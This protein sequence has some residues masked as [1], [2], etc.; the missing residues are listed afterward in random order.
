MARSLGKLI[1][2]ELGGDFVQPSA[3]RDVLLKGFQPP[4]RAE[5]GLLQQVFGVLQR[6]K[7][8]IAMERQFAAVGFGELKKGLYAGPRFSD[9]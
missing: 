1:E 8:A 7:H 6:A 2:R 9:H 5:Q 4:P 3:N